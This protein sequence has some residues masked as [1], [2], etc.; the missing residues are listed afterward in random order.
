MRQGSDATRSDARR[1][2]ISRSDERIDAWRVACMYVHVI[3]VRYTI[4]GFYVG[5]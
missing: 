1:I 2:V 4:Y 5:L 3:L